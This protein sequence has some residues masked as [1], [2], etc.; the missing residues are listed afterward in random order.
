M[1]TIMQVHKTVQESKIPLYNVTTMHQSKRSIFLSVVKYSN[2]SLQA[3]VR[4]NTRIQTNPQTIILVTR[5][6]WTP[7][8]SGTQSY[9]LASLKV[10]NK[11]AGTVICS[12]KHSLAKRS[13]IKV[14][15]LIVE[16]RQIL[17]MEN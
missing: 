2:N 10:T 12:A 15:M 14:S 1:I 17:K 16:T 9:V 11:Q 4:C 7:G 3:Q 5:A 13:E 6:T 8:H